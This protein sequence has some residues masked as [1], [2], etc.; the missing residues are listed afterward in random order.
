MLN[1]VISLFLSGVALGM[2]PCM[3]SC[4]P[5]LISYS[6]ATKTGLKDSIRLYLIF[7]LSRIIAYL[8]LGVL[9]GFLSE[10][11]I[12]QNYQMHLSRFF[13]FAGGIF[14]FAIGLLIILG[15]EPRFKLCRLLRKNLIENDAK[16]IFI[17][18]LVIGISPC[19]P[20]IGV[21]SYIGMVSFSW[22]KGL[23]LSLS[24]GLGTVISPLIFL[25]V[26]S[27]FI[28]KLFKDKERFFIIFQKICGFILCF[29]GLQL[30][31]SAWNYQLARF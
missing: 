8:I 19:A 27:S 18:G 14:I 15:K 9:V 30:F 20:L 13:Y 5:L 4:G 21:L 22:V 1:L 28:N 25:V 24:F 7:S 10:L 29:L 16:S 11:F 23:L 3:A 26:F 31:I 17:F 6:A 12:Y 2:G